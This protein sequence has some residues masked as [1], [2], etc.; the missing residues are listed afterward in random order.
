[1]DLYNFIIGLILILIGCI[2]IFD[3]KDRNQKGLTNAMYRYGGIALIVNGV[4]YII[5]LAF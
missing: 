5:Y 1:M 4:L 2:P 3:N